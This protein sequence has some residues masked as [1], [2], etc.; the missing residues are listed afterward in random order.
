MEE[1]VVECSIVPLFSGIL[2][3]NLYS[4]PLIGTIKI[5]TCHER[6]LNSFYVN[7]IWPGSIL[8]CDYLLKNENY[9]SLCSNKYILELGSGCALP[10]FII[11]KFNPKFIIISDYPSEILLKTIQESIKE[12][13]LNEE[14]I[15]VI[16][17][18]WGD[19]V[20]VLTQSLNCHQTTN[21]FDLIILSEVLWKD[22]YCQHRSILLYLLSSQLHLLSILFLL[23]LL[24]FILI[25]L[26][27]CLGIY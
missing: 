18:R 2:P 17:Y 6:T 22:T 25:Y 11:S 10:S 21:I 12:N 16:G 15:E 3:Y 14:I 7:E 20:S 9:N 24:S 5:K 8:L 1:E 4:N 26:F 19:D 23:H 13:H 27:V